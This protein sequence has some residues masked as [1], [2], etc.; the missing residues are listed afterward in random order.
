M[1]EIYEIITHGGGP[2]MV[3]IFDAIAM[4]NKD[5]TFKAILYIASLY[6]GLWVIFIAFSKSSG[7]ILFKHLMWVWVVTSILWASTVRVK[8][9]DPVNGMTHDVDNVPLLVGYFG[10]RINSIGY[11]VT[12]LIE[13]NMTDLDSTRKYRNSGMAFGSKAVAQ[14]SNMKISNADLYQNVES[15]INN[16]V[17]MDAAI[18]TKYTYEDIR[19]SDNIFDLVFTDGHPIFG[20]YYRPFEI[21]EKGTPPKDV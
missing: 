12:K 19:T 10:S 20:I 2:A 1:N 15:Y 9:T 8:V 13:N 16:C 6:A 14:I 4:T 3:K 21:R 7:A 17:V 18:G 11:G 5:E